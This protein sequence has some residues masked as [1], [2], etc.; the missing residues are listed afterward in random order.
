METSWEKASVQGNKW[1]LFLRWCELLALYQ[2]TSANTS[3]GLDFRAHCINFDLLQDGQMSNWLP[4]Q[5]RLK[6][7]SQTK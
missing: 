1:G 6:A 4:S 7:I 5:M 2:R 3:E